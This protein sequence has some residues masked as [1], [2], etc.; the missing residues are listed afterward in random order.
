EKLDVFRGD[1]R[2]GARSLAKEPDLAQRRALADP[3]HDSLDAVEGAPDLDR[4]RVEHVGLAMRLGALLEDDVALL[5]PPPL[6]IAEREVLVELEPDR[7]QRRLRLDGQ[8]R[9]GPAA[10]AALEDADTLEAALAEDLRD[11]RALLLLGARA[12]GDDHLLGLEVDR[13]ALGL[14]GLEPGRARELQ[15]ARL[16]IGLGPHVEQRRI[17]PALD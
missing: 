11:A 9:V 17:E 16:E 15:R 14:L 10:K 12:V 8:A 4:A 3:V 7:R 6:D 1:G 13:R 2:R 5:E